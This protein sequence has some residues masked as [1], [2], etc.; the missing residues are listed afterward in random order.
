MLEIIGQAVKE[1]PQDLREAYPSVEWRAIA[2][3]RDSVAHEYFRVDLALV[4]GMVTKDIP[5]LLDQVRGILGE[6]PA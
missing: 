3:A 6:L 4:W 2:G 1:L 5:V